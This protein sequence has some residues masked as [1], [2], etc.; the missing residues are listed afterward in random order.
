MPGL[1]GGMQGSDSIFGTRLPMHGNDSGR[2]RHRVGCCLLRRAHLL[3][4]ALRA[5]P[6]KTWFCL[7]GGGK[8]RIFQSRML[9]VC[10]MR[11]RVD[12]VMLVW[13]GGRKKTTGSARRAATRT[14][15]SVR[16]P[17]QLV[18]VCPC[19]ENASLV[20]TAHSLARDVWQAT[21]ATSARA[22]RRDRLPH[23]PKPAATGCAQ[24]GWLPR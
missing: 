5:F 9:C 11:E 3:A 14:T 4:K 15:H 13:C 6:L 24:V 16:A 7:E 10:A 20:S 21:C 1:G 22:A 18:S 8:R 23:R 12:G 17:S 19:A 2:K